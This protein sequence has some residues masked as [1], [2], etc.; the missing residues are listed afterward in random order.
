MNNHLKKIFWIALFL[1][2]AM[3]AGCKKDKKIKTETELKKKENIPNYDKMVKFLS[4]VLNVSKERIIYNEEE[5]FFFIP[6]T[7]FKESLSVVKFRYDE[8]NEY[9]LTYENQ[10]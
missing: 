3:T 1:P 10:K 9:K 7:P 6:N 5:M 4:V 2:I 8:A